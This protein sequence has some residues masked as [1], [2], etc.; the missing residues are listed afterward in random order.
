[1]SSHQIKTRSCN[2]KQRQK[3]T[4]ATLLSVLIFLILMSVVGVAASKITV[5]DILVAG[6]DQMQMEVYQETS[7]NLRK[8][9][10]VIALSDPLLKKDGAYFDQDT[11]IYDVPEDTENPNTEAKI[12]DVS[13]GDREK[14]YECEAGG[15]AVSV[16]QNVP[17]CFLYEFQLM[18]SKSNSGARDRHVRGAGKEFPNPGDNKLF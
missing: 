17:H 5:M 8:L 16:G 12:K 2:A 4:G 13:K 9:A 10:T 15:L 6:N 18:Q 1:M 3:Q 14:F 11:G 7:N